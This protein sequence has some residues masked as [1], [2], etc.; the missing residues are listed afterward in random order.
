VSADDRPARTFDTG[1]QH[2]RTALAW[3]RTA[4]SIM[5]TGIVF[6]RYAASDSHIV[7]AFVGLL[8][9]AFGSG[10]LV[11]AGWHYE[12]LHGALRQ[13]DD[14]VHPTAARLVGLATVAASGL[15]LALAVLITLGDA[16]A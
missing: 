10:V 16:T 13:G 15:G 2:E 12:D 9:T 1:L 11:W 7:V 3:E 6:A 4:I 8:L 5:V 14:V